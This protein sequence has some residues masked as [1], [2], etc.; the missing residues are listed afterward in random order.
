MQKST[1]HAKRGLPR[2]IGMNTQRAA[3][4]AYSAKSSRFF[5]WQVNPQSGKRCTRIGHE[6][7]AAG[8]VD[9]RLGSISYDDTKATL[10]CGN[11]GCQARR[12]AT[13]YEDVCCFHN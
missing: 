2:K 9:W 3:N 5:C 4:E 10:P 12:S 13:D 8:F 6:P 7:F 11:S 1:P